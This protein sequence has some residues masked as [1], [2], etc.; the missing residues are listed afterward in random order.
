MATVTALRAYAHETAQEATQGDPAETQATTAVQSANE[1]A[2][3]PVQSEAHSVPSAPVEMGQ[4]D[5]LAT[6]RGYRGNVRE[7]PMASGALY[8]GKS[9]GDAIHDA[10]LAAAL[11]AVQ[12]YDADAEKQFANTDWSPTGRAKNLQPKIGNTVMAVMREYAAVAEEERMLA[13]EE[14]T[15]YEVPPVESTAAADAVLDGQARAWVM[16]LTGDARAKAVRD[17]LGGRLPR[18]AKALARSPIPTGIDDD[19]V[20]AAWRQAV[21]AENPDKATKI[22]AKRKA[23]DSQKFALT[24]V[25]GAL[26]KS[27]GVTRETLK[28]AMDAR[29]TNRD[30]YGP[31]ADFLG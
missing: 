5:K 21:D 20:Q 6:G 30:A 16:G 12:E 18:V 4:V 24:R 19:I 25:A 13:H 22:A 23:V 27:K 3:A 17:L 9:D 2:R 28:A 11:R 15:L 10:S 7:V 1:P 26:T 31:F 14:R 29:G 8:L